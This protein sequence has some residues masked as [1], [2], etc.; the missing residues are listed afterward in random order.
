[1]K[2]ILYILICICMTLYIVTL[3]MQYTKKIGG[4]TEEKI[5]NNLSTYQSVSSQ[6]I[7]GI[8]INGSRNC[9]ITDSIQDQLNK[10]LAEIEDID[11]KKEWFLEYKEIIDRY[12]EYFD[13]PETIYDVYTDEEIELICRAVETECYDCD[14]DSKCNVASVILNRINYENSIFGDTVSEVITRDS[15]FAYGRSNITN[16]TIL[17]VMYA[18]EIEDTTGG[19]VA[20]R[21]DQKP[22][23][24]HGWGYSFTDSCGHHFYKEKENEN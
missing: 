14:F 20:F 23:I 5:P 2:K 24:W 8:I 17:S 15:Q 9:N 19:C 18:Y 22:D 21:S 3:T 6:C 7:K 1:M 11:N 16:D 13:V 4:N 12:S 10:E